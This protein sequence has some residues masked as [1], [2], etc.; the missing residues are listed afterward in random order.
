MLPDTISSL[1]MDNF[2]D[3]VKASLGAIGN[4]MQRLDSKQDFLTSAIANSKSA[5]SRLFDADAAKEA[6]NS[7]RAQIGSQAATAMFSQLNFAPQGVLQLL[8]G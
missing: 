5:Y 8:G 6:L 4:Y 7:T 2:E 3:S 1:D